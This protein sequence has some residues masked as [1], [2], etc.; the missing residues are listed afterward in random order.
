MKTT[1]AFD[2]VDLST[3]ENNLFGDENINNKHFTEFGMKN[4]T[5]GTGELT[6]MQL[7]KLMNPMNYI[8]TPGT[9]TAKNWR[10]RVG[11]KDADTSTAISLILATALQNKGI[12]VDYVI[13]WGIPHSGDYDTDELTAWIDSIAR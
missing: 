3:G 2:G 12:N 10:I 1:P 8:V 6:D 13:A 11:S 9:N 4:D 7:V 5:T